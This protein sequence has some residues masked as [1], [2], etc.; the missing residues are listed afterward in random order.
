MKKSKKNIVLS[1]GMPK[2]PLSAYNI[3]FRQERPLLLGRKAK[4]ESQPDFDAILTNAMNSG[5]S[6][7]RGALFQ[8]A[9]RTLGTK[10]RSISSVT[11]RFV[12]SVFLNQ[13]LISFIHTANRWKQMN[14]I[15]KEVFEKMADHAMEEY[16]RLKREYMLRSENLPVIATTAILRDNHLRANTNSLTPQGPSEPA[17]EARPTSNGND[18][19]QTLA[20]TKGSQHPESNTSPISDTTTPAVQVDNIQYPYPTIRDPHTIAFPGGS[21]MP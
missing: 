16:K 20:V 11:L 5:K 10:N 18:N 3:Y 4:G 6:N 1:P 19:D 12:C 9:S 14:P 8:A 13:C 17:A 21:E 2:R 15:E 7:H